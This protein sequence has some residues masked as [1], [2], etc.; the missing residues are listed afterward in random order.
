MPKDLRIAC[1]HPL[2]LHRAHPWAHPSNGEGDG[3][4]KRR[5]PHAMRVFSGPPPRRWGREIQQHCTTSAFAMSTPFPVSS[6]GMGV[7]QDSRHAAAAG[8]A[9]SDSLARPQRPARRRREAEPSVL[10]VLPK[11]VVPP[12]GDSGEATALS[13]RP[14]D[15]QGPPASLVRWISGSRPVLAATSRGRLLPTFRS[16]I[17]RTVWPPRRPVRRPA[18]DGLPRGSCTGGPRAGSA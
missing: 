6:R 18:T 17:R 8:S 10:P 9:R 12:P 7:G 11:T 13:T 5:S 14:A 15:Y 16:C 3:P 2:G 1:A 4:Y